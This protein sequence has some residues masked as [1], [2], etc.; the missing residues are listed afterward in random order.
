MEELLTCLTELEKLKTVERGLNVGNRKESTAEH[1]WSC[2]LL[3]DILIEFIEEPLNRHQVLEYLLY[4]DAVEVYAGDAKFNN[5]NEMEAKHQKELDA[6]KRIVALLPH[7]ERF[8]T[9]VEQY[10]S[11][12]SREAQFAKAIDCIDALVRN[13]NDANNRSHDGFTEELIRNKYTPHVARFPF[14]MELFQTL[15]GKLKEQNKL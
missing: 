7:P 13:L 1:S 14:L 4:H 11:R 9:L 15:M 6:M 5:P 12:K 10:E 2:M 3:A 8:R